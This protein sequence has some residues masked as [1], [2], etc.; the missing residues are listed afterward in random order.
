MQ[1]SWIISEL[2]LTLPMMKQN[3]TSCSSFLRRAWIMY[4][5]R[6]A[7]TDLYKVLY[8]GY[9]IWWRR[10]K[11]DWQMRLYYSKLSCWNV[12]PTN[13][14]IFK[15]MRGCASQ[16]LPEVQKHGTACIKFYN[17]KR[18]GFTCKTL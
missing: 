1:I 16:F 8:L 11:N 7:F 3:F 15:A 18:V 14:F 9:Q 13:T 12:C 4:Y 5:T 2:L 17:L 10:N 6:T